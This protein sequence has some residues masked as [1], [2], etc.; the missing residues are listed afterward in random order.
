[1]TVP[2]VIETLEDIEPIPDSFY[3]DPVILEEGQF[4]IRNFQN[5]IL[6]LHKTHEQKLDTQT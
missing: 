2:N 1:M 3:T 4:L 6:I 5:P